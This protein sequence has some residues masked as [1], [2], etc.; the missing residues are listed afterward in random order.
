MAKNN[1]YEELRNYELQLRDN[2]Y[3]DERKNKYIEPTEFYIG[4]Q[5]DTSVGM[6]GSYKGQSGKEYVYD[7]YEKLEKDVF[8]EKKISKISNDL[9]YVD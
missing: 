1:I 8:N 3:Y 7:D 4:T 5:E 9:Y 2:G 6:F